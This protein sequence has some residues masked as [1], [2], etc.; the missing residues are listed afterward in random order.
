[1]SNQWHKSRNSSHVVHRLIGSIPGSAVAKFHILLVIAVKNEPRINA[2]YVH[3][4]KESA[5]DESPQDNA[6]SFSRIY[7]P[8]TDKNAH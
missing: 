8:K 5:N 2:V 7:Y 6:H 3:L 4:D 1:M